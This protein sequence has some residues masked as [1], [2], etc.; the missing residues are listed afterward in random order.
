M[1]RQPDERDSAPR[2]G[3]LSELRLRELLTEV[4]ERIVQIVDAR[5]HVDGLLEAMLSVTSGLDLDNTLRTIVHAAINLVDARY[6][7]LGVVSPR[8]GLSEFVFEGIDEETRERIGDL[9]RGRGVLGFLITNP[10]PV[11]LKDLSHHAASVGFPDH[12]PPMKTFLGV[13]IQIRDEAFWNLY[14]TEKANG[15]QFTED[16]EVLLRALAAAAG[17]AIEN[18][19]L[20]EE[21]RTRQAWLEATREIATELLAGSET[22]EVLQVITDDALSLTDADSAFLAVPDDPDI[23]SDEVTE[24][25]VTASAGTVSARIGRTIPL[26]GSTSG[27]AFRERTPLRVNALAFDP[28]FE[29]GTRFGPALALPLRATQ[30]VAGVLV[31][32]RHADAAPFTED[33]LALMS[34]FADQAAVALQL[35]NSQRR[36]HELDV[37]SDRDRIARD[38]HDHVIQRLFAV[39]LSLQSTLQRA[40]SPEVKQRLGQSV[41]DLH[42][43]VRDIRTAI[44]DL[45][46][47][48][49]AVTQF[50]R[51]LHEI[52][53]EITAD[54]G[55]RT[56]VHMSGPLSVIDAV[57]AEHAEAVL[58]EALSNA[59]RHAAAGTVTVSISVYDDLVIEVADDGK[60]FPEGV[61]RSGLDNLAARAQEVNGRFTIDTTPGGGTTLRWSAPLP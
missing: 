60:G 22:A 2:L 36:M 30:S 45:H 4:Q 48:S 21:S 29:T 38:L 39:G 32:L 41:D 33:Q 3:S 25:V 6:G 1:T 43:I 56:T 52:I 23:P 12:H 47:G 49:G 19:R 59:V 37:L 55:L 9:P 14:L 10:K 40:K 17:I 44:F 8:E 53:A 13:P 18:A 28:G 46:G 5:E 16:D 34:G 11:R 42:D 24:L 20:Y 15:A 54:S 27:E 35:A 50:R 31:V 57:L 61:S 26:E 51:R 7:A 58:R